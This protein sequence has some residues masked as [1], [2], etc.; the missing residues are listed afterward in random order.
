MP[1]LVGI[2]S[3]MPRA[4]A[5]SEVLRM[6]QALLHEPSYR[7]GTWCDDSLGLYVGWVERGNAAAIGMPI[8]NG[9]GDVTLF[10]SGEEYS[11]P[12]K[13]TPASYLTCSYNQQNDFPA[14]LNGRFHGVV[15]DQRRGLA[16]LFNDRFGIHRLYYYES[17]DATY[18]A[19]E[20]K[21]ILAVKPELRNVDQRGLGEFVACGC[22]LE[23][24]TLFQ[25]IRVVP[26]ASAWIVR[27][28]AVERKGTYFE[29]RTW[30]EQETLE[31][32]RYY[33]QLR[34]VFS[35]LLPR[36]FAG[37]DRLGM[38]V[39][40]GLDS[41]MIMAWE[42]PPAG[43]VPCY[44]FGGTYRECQDVLLARRLVALWG[45]PYD[46][47][48]V[49]DEFLA[50][51][52][53]QAARTVYLTDGCADVS[54]T[55]DLFVNER[56]Q[57]IAPIRMTGNYGSEVLRGARPAFGPS[58]PPAGLFR[59]DLMVEVQRA[60]QTYDTLHQGHPLSFAVF[61]QAPWHH[62][63]LLALEQTQLAVRSPYLDN[64]VVRTVFRAP[65]WTLSTSDISLRLIHDGNPKMAAMRSDRGVGGDK[66]SLQKSLVRNWLEFTF[67]AEY[68]YD[69]GMPQWLARIDHGFAALHLERLFLGRHKFYHYRVWY[70]DQLASYVREMLL[71]SRTLQRPYLEGKVLE[72]MVR[73]HVR[74][75][76]NY[77]TAIH[78]VLT[79]ELMHRQLVESSE[80]GIR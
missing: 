11:R 48:E 72:N 58:E 67:K 60:R 57:A 24:R 74:G 62:Y 30:E 9:S 27:A 15:A 3:K 56:A 20:A 2:I 51:F 69:Y 54:R 44:S 49:G 23:N 65:L 75:D 64:E 10:F 73:R 5:E 19:A 79:L 70:R 71:D 18:F 77:T 61:R 38:S 39:T 80:P 63:G 55:A 13:A 7:S 46:V 37:S 47:I 22:V 45:Q 8:A 78:K 53:R 66:S 42:Q 16:T 76:G 1:G 12:L 40:G 21:A 33:S 29:P 6:V 26:G 68:A 43:S 32:E 35:S 41:R 50:N 17:A 59:P 4:R 14:G 52:P 31:T 25:G 28:G 36:Y 34:E